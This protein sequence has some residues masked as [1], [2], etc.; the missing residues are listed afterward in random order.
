MVAW[1]R[2]EAI[3]AAVDADVAEAHYRGLPE[4]VR[5]RAE[6]GQL[7]GYRYLQACLDPQRLRNSLD[8]SSEFST[9]AWQR[10]RIILIAQATGRVGRSN[11]GRGC[12]SR[13]V[14]GFRTGPGVQ[15]DVGIR[16]R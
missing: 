11:P 15:P 14:T 6:A 9:K 10:T 5:S 12:D 16:R 4:E 1:I 13:C 8:P 3:A 2:E 7:P